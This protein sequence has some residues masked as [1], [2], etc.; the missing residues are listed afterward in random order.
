MWV[1]HLAP[2]PAGM[3]DMIRYPWVADNTRLGEV[4]GYTPRLDSRQ[5]LES[6]IAARLQS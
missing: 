1:L 6:F 3:L 2:F 5:A 4:L